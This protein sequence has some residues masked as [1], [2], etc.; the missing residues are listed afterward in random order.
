MTGDGAPDDR[1]PDDAP[2][3]RPWPVV[4]TE[5]V[6]DHEFFAAGYDVLER[7]DGERVN[8]YWIDANDVAVIVPVTD[9]GR[10]VLIE[11]RSRQLRGRTVGCPAGRCEDGETHAE[12]AARE[13]REETGYRAGTLEPLGTFRPD[14]W[15]RM[16][17]AV[18]AATE[19]RAGERDLDDAESITVREVP[20]D[21]ALATALDAEVVHGTQV[22][23]LLFA[24]EAGLL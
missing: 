4:D 7:P 15:V 22:V 16:D 10:V 8:Y 13:L 11:E 23:P 9:D 12:A 18:F 24:H 19:L 2:P 17:A 20:A 6:W 14:A 1:A 21:E 5:V 3:D